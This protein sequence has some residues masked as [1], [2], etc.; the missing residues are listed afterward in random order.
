MKAIAQAPLVLALAALASAETKPCT[1]LDEATKKYFDLSPL[2]KES[3]DDWQPEAFDTGYKFAF[4][5]CH[6]LASPNSR[7]KNAPQV[8]ASA[9]RDGQ[10]WS[11]GE[12]NSN[13]VVRGDQLILKYTDGETCSANQYTRTSVMSFICDTQMKGL[14]TPRY[15]GDGNQCTYFFEWRTPAACS[16][17]EPSGGSTFA[18]LLVAGF[19]LTSIYLFCG[20]LYNRVVNK[21]R[22]LKQIPHYNLWRSI[23]DFIKDM[24]QIVGINL[25]YF[26][27]K[28]RSGPNSN[29]YQHVGE[30]DAN[31]L[32]D[33]D[34]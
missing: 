5:V 22:G 8:G 1:Y 33:D 7:L 21:S 24:A 13:L 11:L 25:F 28:K 18:T 10:V 19:I 20:V 2:A 23:F 12:F 31:A 17:S 29:R 27:Q 16:T 14:G 34:F 30:S 6:K 9:E 3:G 32:I 26:I 15:I 4:N